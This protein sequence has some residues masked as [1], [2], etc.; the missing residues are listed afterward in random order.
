MLNSS[1]GKRN[2]NEIFRPFPVS[3]LVVSPPIQTNFFPFLFANGMEFF[4]PF[5]FSAEIF[6]SVCSLIYETSYVSA[7]IPFISVH[8]TEDEACEDLP[9]PCDVVVV[10]VVVVVF[11]FQL[12]DSVSRE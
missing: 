10:I 1:Y 6:R 2:G 12:M 5:C 9:V 3:L 4:A 7:E 8:V 11:P